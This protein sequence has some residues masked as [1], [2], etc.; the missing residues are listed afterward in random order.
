MRALREGSKY[1]F[2][3]LIHDVMPINGSRA[4]KYGNE[5]AAVFLQGRASYCIKS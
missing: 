4:P 5:E 1:A 3:A 2:H